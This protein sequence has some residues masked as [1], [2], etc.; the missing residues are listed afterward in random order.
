[1][2][3]MSNGALVEEGSPEMGFFPTRRARNR[4][5]FFKH[6]EALKDSGDVL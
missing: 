2:P 6:T 1:M 3:F 4:T 5:L